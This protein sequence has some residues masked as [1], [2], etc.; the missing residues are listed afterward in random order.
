MSAALTA[1]PRPTRPTDDYEDPIPRRLRAFIARKALKKIDALVLAE[2]RRWAVRLK[3]TCWT[4]K[5]TIAAA[6]GV[7]RRTVQSSLRRLIRTGWIEQ[8]I[9]E[10]PDPDDPRNNTGYRYNFLW[11]TRGY[12]ELPEPPMPL[13][14]PPRTHGPASG[15]AC[16]GLGGGRKI[17]P[18][19]SDG[20]SSPAPPPPKKISA[21][22]SKD[23][24]HPPERGISPKGFRTGRVEEKT[25]DVCAREGP[26]DR[27]RQGTLGLDGGR[28][29]RAA[30][31]AALVRR[32]ESRGLRFGIAC[33][34][35]PEWRV[36]PGVDPPDAIEAAELR[37]HR[38]EVLELLRA[39]ARDNPNAAAQVP[40]TRR[41][42]PGT[43]TGPA[44]AEPAELGEVLSRYREGPPGDGREPASPVD[45]AHK[46]IGRLGPDCEP[47]ERAAAVRAL[48]D[49]TG[50]HQDP[51]ATLNLMRALVRKTCE[52]VFPHS[53]GLLD[54]AVDEC[55]R[56]R[57]RDRGAAF[58]AAVSRRVREAIE[59]RDAAQPG[60]SGLCDAPDLASLKS[61]LGAPD[62][63]AKCK[64][65]PGG[66]AGAK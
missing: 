30:E 51:D 63:D 24:L 56:P 54:G 37:E 13:F 46:R 47:S 23:F 27:P 15:P 9:V 34:G 38:A 64:D 31:A 14:E 19:P 11:L 41:R 59:K 25:S 3:H 43:P 26:P 48:M 44:T 53:R 62:W 12:P 57:V 32:L 7:T 40:A 35:R 58:T 52:G 10:R 2:L 66:G 21:A 16:E 61:K 1:P 45:R 39:R 49:A 4:T 8:V 50:P 22:G 20:A 36:L 5:A 42:P 29:A 28:E 65:L 17:S 6:L 55:N 33:D 18:P 60:L